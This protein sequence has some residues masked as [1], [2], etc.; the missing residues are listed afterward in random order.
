MNHN[1][2][3]PDLSQFDKRQ[4]C[5]LNLSC[6]FVILAFTVLIANPVWGF[7]FSLLFFA[8]AL[9]LLWACFSHKI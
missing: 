2:P 8:A 3:G 6:V 9:V 5:Y 7:V 1:E 4:R